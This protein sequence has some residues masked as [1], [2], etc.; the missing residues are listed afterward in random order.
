MKIFILTIIISLSV[1][2]YASDY[3]KRNGVLSLTPEGGYARFNINASYDATSGVCELDGKAMPSVAQQGQ[4][5]RW[6]YNDQS[7]MCI[8]VISELRSGAMQVITK[9]CDS[10]C[11]VSAIGAMDGKYKKNK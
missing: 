11:G 5:N 9:D 4:R 1:S 2:A 6:V 3:K 10:Y 7:S 8:A